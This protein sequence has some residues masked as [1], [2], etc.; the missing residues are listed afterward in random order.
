MCAGICTS[1]LFVFAAQTPRDRRRVALLTHL[2]RAVSYISIGALFGG[3]GAAVFGVL[4]RP[5]AYHIL[6]WGAA[7]ALLWIGLSTAELLP[8]FA[9]ADRAFGAISGTILRSATSSKLLRAGPLI[10]GLSWGCMPCAMIYGAYTLAMLTG[11]VVGGAAAMAGFALATLPGLLVASFG[12]GKLGS[13]ARG[14]VRQAVGLSI[15]ALGLLSVYIT[16]SALEM[17]C[18]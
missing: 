13:S 10:A 11:S 3:A 18:R 17:I 16:P 2:G 15:A 6:Q 8:N 1:T 7:V 14:I 5:A 12:F 9:F 4:P